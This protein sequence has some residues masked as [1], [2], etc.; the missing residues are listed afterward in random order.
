MWPNSL[1]SFNLYHFVP[2]K[3][4][5]TVLFINHSEQ[6][7]RLAIKSKSQTGKEKQ[8]QSVILIVNPANL[9]QSS[10]LTHYRKS[11]SSM[12]ASRC[13]SV[14][15][16]FLRTEQAVLLKNKP[17]TFSGIEDVYWD[18]V[19]LV[20]CLSK[21]QPNVGLICTNREHL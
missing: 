11:P 20:S 15:P 19:C 8:R 13:K 16:F 7:Q 9:S 2:L 4:L 6:K 18:N 1:L 14:N 10:L 12:Y 3:P 21:F 17:K 5:E